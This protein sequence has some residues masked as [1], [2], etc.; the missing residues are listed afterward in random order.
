MNKYTRCLLAL[1][2][3]VALALVVTGCLQRPV[4]VAEPQAV[5]NRPLTPYYAF[6]EYDSDEDGWYIIVD[7]SDSTNYPH[8]HTNRIIL[9][10]FDFWGD[11]N[12]AMRWRWELGVVTAVTTSTTTIEWIAGGESS[13]AGVFSGSLRLPEHGL[14]LSVVNGS[15]NRVATLEVTATSEITTTTEISTTV[16]L[17]GTVG[18]G[19]L[20]LHTDEITDTAVINW[21]S[22][23]SYDTE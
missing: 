8:V 4:E 22:G 3:G 10:S 16:G 7:L 21:S 17:T 5:G 19:D 11:L 18:V 2:L 9:K 15:L 23:V 12:A 13:S 20:I 6:I 14:S 1:G